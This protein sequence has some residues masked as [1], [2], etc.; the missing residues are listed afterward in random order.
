MK[1]L[2]FLSLFLLSCAEPPAQIINSNQGKLQINGKEC[3]IIRIDRGGGA[4]LWFIDC[5]AGSSSVNFQSGKSQQTVG[6]YIPPTSCE[7]QHD[8]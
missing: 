3:Q 6:Q 1:N 5:G 7:C 8:H 2:L 4:Y